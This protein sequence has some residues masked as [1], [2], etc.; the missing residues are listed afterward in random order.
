MEPTVTALPDRDGQCA[1]RCAGGFD[2]GHPRAAG[3]RV[4]HSSR[5]GDRASGPGRAPRRLRGLIHPQPAP[6]PP[7]G[8]RRGGAT[9]LS[10]P[11]AGCPRGM[12][13]HTA[14]AGSIQAHRLLDGRVRLRERLCGAGGARVRSGWAGC[15][16]QTRPPCCCHSMV[17]WCGPP[18]P[19]RGNSTRITAHSPSLRWG[20]QSAGPAPHPCRG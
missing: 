9:L 18:R 16:S 15:A 14:P 13:D 5:A 19:Q 20:R 10:T 2:A 6:H 12:A 1:V 8:A 4:R 17:R 3:G 7:A 11:P